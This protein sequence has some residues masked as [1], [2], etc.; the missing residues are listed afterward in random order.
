MYKVKRY[1]SNQ[2]LRMLYHI[3]TNWRVR[4]IIF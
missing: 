1:M 3:L 4:C 2:T